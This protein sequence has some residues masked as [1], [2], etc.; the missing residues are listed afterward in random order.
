MCFSSSRIIPEILT[1]SDG[2]YIGLLPWR[3]TRLFFRLFQLYTHVTQCTFKWPRDNLAA[4][5]SSTMGPIFATGLT[6]L[7]VSVMPLASLRG[8]PI[9]APRHISQHTLKGRLIAISQASATDTL[10][11]LGLTQSRWLQGS[12][13]LSHTLKT[14][15]FISRDEM[16]ARN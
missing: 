3:F 12:Y 13:T 16:S 14:P 1:G 7:N 10:L 5:C 4:T 15:A 8:A 9:H 11:I 2:T 6:H